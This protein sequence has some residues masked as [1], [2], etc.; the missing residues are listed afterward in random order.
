MKIKK[1]IKWT[2][3]I[4]I[5]L[6]VVLQIGVDFIL[7]KMNPVGLF[8]NKNVCR[9]DTCRECHPQ[10][11]KEWLDGQRA[12]FAAI[13]PI[14]EADQAA[15][16]AGPLCWKCHDPF[17]Q[18][19]DEGVTC[20]FCHGKS[21]DTGCEQEDIDHH[22]SF[23][24]M[25]L[26]RLKGQKWCF[27]CHSV[28]QP[29][30]GADLQG[31]IK[32]W[33]QSKA[34]QEGLMCQSCHMPIVGDGEM[35][36]HFHGHYYPGRNPLKG[37]ES[38]SI[39]EITLENGVIN[40]FV[41]NHLTSHYLPSGAHT[42]ALFLEVTCFDEKNEPIFKDKY[43]FLKRFKFKKFLGIQELPYEVYKDTR[44]KPE[45]VRQVSFTTDKQNSTKKI[46]ATL[47]CGFIGDLGEELEAWTSDY[48]EEKAAIF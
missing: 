45:E 21:G 6:V 24:K 41:K 7:V 3:L 29:L 15:E 11:Y 33:E 4:L 10:Q 23:R 25:G 14:M 37:R 9:A 22:I 31:T 19:L 27:Q 28:I 35:K 36:H 32:E 39:E 34:R 17:K 20:E 46:V 5:G 40:V 2:V 1:I 8:V 13:R 47:R 42:K 16:A 43:L 18:G 30:T 12:A 26:E 44:I 48:I 38:L